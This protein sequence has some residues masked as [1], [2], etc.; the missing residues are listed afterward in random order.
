MPPKLPSYA[1][2]VADCVYVLSNFIATT[3]TIS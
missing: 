3:M 1:N 2:D